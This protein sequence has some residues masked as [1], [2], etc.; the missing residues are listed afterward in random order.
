MVQ[1]QTPGVDARPDDIGN[2]IRVGISQRTVVS[3]PWYA[4]AAGA[5]E[6][7]RG[8]DFPV[9]RAA[10]AG[11]GLRPVEQATGRLSMESV[12]ARAAI[13]GAIVGA[14][15]GWLLGLFNVMTPRIADA[16]V[17][18]VAVARQRPARQGWHAPALK[19]CGPSSG[20]R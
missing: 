19:R 8:E 9:D 15:L 11:R 18:G 2:D 5:V 4:D 16:W 1:Q 14:L 6:R 10:V 13:S 7:L 3:Y 20:D 17:I 12:A